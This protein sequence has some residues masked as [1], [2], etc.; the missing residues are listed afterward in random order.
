M[1]C[2]AKDYFEKSLKALNIFLEPDSANSIFGYFGCLLEKNR[3]INLISRQTSPL[4]AVS[5]HLVDSLSL[6][7][8]ELPKELDHL[9]FGSGG[10][11]PGIPLQLANPGWRTSLAEASAKKS[12]FLQE[13]AD[14]FSHGNITV[15]NQFLEPKG[16]SLR[17]KTGF[18]DLVTVRA[19]DKLPLLVSAV[20][21]LVKGGGLL[22]A[23]KGP[24]YMDEL[25]ASKRDVKKNGL[26]LEK[27][28]EFALPFS[29]IR[30]T[31]L[32]FRKFE[33]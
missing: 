24:N 17:E 18:F 8:A 16:T 9:D 15:I 2:D 5:A 12:A 6:L 13:M 23:Y 7:Q 14:R 22:V 30:R 11:L 28:I 21:H 10:G 33:G 3:Q 32:F 20:A 26:E 1:T 27:K 29:D 31:L 4:R 19:V 25:R